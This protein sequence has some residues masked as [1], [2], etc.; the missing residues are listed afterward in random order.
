MWK[1]HLELSRFY[2]VLESELVG[3]ADRIFELGPKDYPEISEVRWLKLAL[4]LR[5]VADHVRAAGKTHPLLPGFDFH[6]AADT[7]RALRRDIQKVYWGELDDH[8][9]E[10]E[11]FLRDIPHADKD[12]CAPIGMKSAT[13]EDL[14]A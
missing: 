3:N 13:L 2:E 8:L 6:N 9:K 14:A 10:I 7:I 5:R 11:L 4:F 1:S 12:R